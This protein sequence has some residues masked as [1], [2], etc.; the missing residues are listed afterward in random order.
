MEISDTTKATALTPEFLAQYPN[1]LIY[2][3]HL[4][5]T[6]RACGEKFRQFEMEHQ[7]A[8][9]TQAAPS[10]G[11]AMHEGIA[12]YRLAKKDSKIYTEAYDLGAKAL[13][14]SYKM[15]MPTESQ[16]EVMQDDKRSAR[17]ALRLYTGHTEHYEPVGLKFLYVETP[18]AMLLGQISLPDPGSDQH[19][20]LRDVIYVGIIDAV[21]EWQSRI[22]VNEIKTS[23]WRI[24][25][26]ILDGFAMDQS[27]IGY[28]VATREL[29]GIDT[30]YGL[31]HMMWVASP[32]KSGKGKPLDEYYY[33]KELYWDQ[34]Q[35]DEWRRNTLN[36]IQ[37]IE[38]RKV[39]GKWIADWGQNCGA[40]GGCP[41][42]PVCMSTPDAR[43]QLLTMDYERKIW[44]PLEDERLQKITED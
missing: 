18:F 6:Y 41:Y 20:H 19:S 40:Y 22:Y 27:F 12:Q 21:V 11:I 23:A 35:M 13:L 2:D 15:N 34:A 7:I 42:R 8:K 44:T 9:K 33:T 39:D 14:E 1:A 31:L 5:K 25:Q 4:I 16:S 24:D 37:E 38:M 29:L 30:N 36:T 26:N 10:F 3:G 28:V 43:A 17:N 32:P